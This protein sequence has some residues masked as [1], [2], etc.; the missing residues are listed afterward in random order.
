MDN[1]EIRYADTAT[2]FTQPVTYGIY[3]NNNPG[4]QDPWNSTPACGFPFSSSSLAP[5]P[6]VATLINGGLSQQVVG[7]G[8]YAMLSNFLLCGCRGI[9]HRERSVP[10]FDGHC[11]RG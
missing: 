10:A 11:S 4:M 6:G 7:V 2:L 3:A 1:T 5:T 8:A 9:S